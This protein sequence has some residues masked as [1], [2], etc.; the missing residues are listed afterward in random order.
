MKKLESTLDARIL[1][2]DGAMGTMIQMHHLSEADFRGTQFQNHT[3]DVKG[4]ND[5]LVLTQPQIIEDIHLQYLQAGADIIETNTFNSNAISMADYHM[6]GLAYDLNLAGAQVA[7][8]AVDKLKEKSPQRE[9]WVAGALG[10]TNRTASM[11][12]DVNN[13]AFRAVTFDDLARA[14][15]DQVRGLVEGGVDLLL[16]ETIFDTLNA[17]AAFF[18]ISQYCEETGKQLPVMASV[19]ITDL[20]GRTLS[21]QL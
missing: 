14:Y 4:N 12:P 21:G 17:K 7:R 16:V 3:C 11:S 19:T 6:E 1:V 2:L 8:R 9:C 10:P 18:A 20:S 5:L 15:Y 13:P